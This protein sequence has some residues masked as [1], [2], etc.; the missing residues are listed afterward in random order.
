MVAE[1]FLGEYFG[2]ATSST[3]NDTFGLYFYHLSY[4]ENISG[5]KDAFLTDDYVFN[6][7]RHRFESRLTYAS[8]DDQTNIEFAEFTVKVSCLRN[9]EITATSK[10]DGYNSF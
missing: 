4:N 10:V 6:G 2:R 9:N 7:L 8:G 3:F 1:K 5:V